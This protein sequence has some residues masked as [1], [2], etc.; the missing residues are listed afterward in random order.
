MLKRI[1]TSAITLVLLAQT[2][3]AQNQEAAQPSGDW[4]IVELLKNGEKLSI[5]LKSGKSIKG[6]LANVTNTGLSISEG[7]KTSSL[8]RDDV[9]RV[10]QV[11]GRTR[12]K[13]A[14]RGAGIGGAIGAGSGLIIYLPARDDNVGVLVPIFGAIG[15]GIGAGVGL[16][17]SG[18]QRRVLI[19]QA[20]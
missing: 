10:Y 8:S 14:L 2:I 18:G 5:E 9:L 16:A 7:T 15:A 3:T 11:I 13:S 4:T 19:Y 20:R 17:F 6:K 12:G 1:L